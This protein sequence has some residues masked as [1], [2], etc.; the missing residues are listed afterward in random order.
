MKHPQQNFELEASR[1]K[2]RNNSEQEIY[3][4]EGVTFLV[5]EAFELFLVVTNKEKITEFVRQKAHFI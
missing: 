5:F 4:S 3:C 2:V 1:N